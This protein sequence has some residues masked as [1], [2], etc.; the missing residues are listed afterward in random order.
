MDGHSQV[1]NSNGAETFKLP[2]NSKNFPDSVDNQNLLRRSNLT[3]KFQNDR[4]EK[5]NALTTNGPSNHKVV[6]RNEI[7]GPKKNFS[8]RLSCVMDYKTTELNG[9]LRR[10]KF[11]GRLGLGVSN[12]SGQQQ[13]EKKKCFLCDKEGVTQVG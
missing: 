3:H 5:H 1:C 6:P 13:K 12:T 4:S 10:N 7:F 2:N 9:S 8:N 11:S